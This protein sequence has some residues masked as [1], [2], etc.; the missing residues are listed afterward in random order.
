LQIQRR[1][2]A[3]TFGEWAGNWLDGA[4]MADTTGFVRKGI[5]VRNILPALEGMLLCEVP[6]DDLRA[7][8]ARV[9]ERGVPATAVHLRDIVKQI[10]AHATLHR[11]KVENPADDVGVASIGTFVPKARVLSALEIWLM[12][13][14]LE[15]LATY[16]MIRLALRLI[17]LTSSIERHVSL[18]NSIAARTTDFLTTFQLNLLLPTGQPVDQLDRPI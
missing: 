13:R 10:Y 11:E 18:E 3:N 15:Q 7:L 9:N 8:R 12:H 14:R 17:L 2:V 4:R 16:P 1:A 6:A 5:V